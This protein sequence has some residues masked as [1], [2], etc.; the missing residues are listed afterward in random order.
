ML[1]KKGVCEADKVSNFKRLRSAG[2]V[3]STLQEKTVPLYRCYSAE[4]RSHFAS[5]ESDCG[6]SG[7]MERLLGYALS[8]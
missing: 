1:D 2:W 7:K 4:E 8:K 6:K 5:N 3:Y